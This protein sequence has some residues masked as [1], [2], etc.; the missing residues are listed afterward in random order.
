MQ[1]QS[2][3]PRLA[4]AIYARW[5]AAN[6]RPAGRGYARALAMALAGAG[7]PR[8][9]PHPTLSALDAHAIRVAVLAGFEELRPGQHTRQLWT[10]ILVALAL[11]IFAL[12]LVVHDE[13]QRGHATPRYLQP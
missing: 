6:D 9:V 8:D 2:Y 5:L 3:D 7:D 1:P 10:R 11:A 13:P 12:G 4:R